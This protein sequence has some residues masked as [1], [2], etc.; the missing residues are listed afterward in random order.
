MGTTVM[1]RLAAQRPDYIEENLSTF[2]ALGPVLVP[3]HHN[4]PLLES[5]L[6]YQDFLFHLLNRLGLY[7]FGYPT[8]RQE[9]VFGL[10]CKEIP[11]I[12]RSV[13]RSFEAS[14]LSYNHE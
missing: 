14:D 4:S 9:F 6:P 10:I 1:F 11:A 2:I 3:W 8:P 13:D 12:C 5:V 7:E